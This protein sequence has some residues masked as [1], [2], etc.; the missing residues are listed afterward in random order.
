MLNHPS[1]TPC[2]DLTAQASGTPPATDVSSD[3]P[4]LAE[5]R[6][7]TRKLNNGR[8][9]GPDGI[10]PELLKCAETPISAALHKLFQN[11]WSSGRVPAEWRDGII[12][13][14]YKGKSHRNQCSSYRPI[15]LLSVPGK[16]FSHVLLSRLEP[17]FA[18]YRRPNQSG[19]TRGRSTLDDIK[20]AF[21]SV[22][23]D[24]FW[25]ALKATGV[26]PLLLQ[27]IQDLHVGS[28]STVRIGSRLR[29][30]GRDTSFTDL[31]YADD[32]ALF[33]GEPAQW[34]VS[35]QRFE[36]EAWMMGM[37]TSWVKTKIQ[38]C[39][40]LGPNPASVTVEGYSVEFTQ[41]FRYLGCDIHSSGYSSPDI[42]RRL[43]LASSTFG[44]LDCVWRNK[45]LKLTTKLRET[46]GIEDILVTIYRRRHSLFG[47][48][49]RLPEDTPAHVAL[50]LSVEA[51][52]GSC[53][54]PTWKRPRGRSR[55]TWVGQLEEDFES[56]AGQMCQSAA[57]RIGW[58]ALRP[59]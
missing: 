13:S 16:V 1:A 36:E 42:L 18:R 17:L 25:K 39:T 54:C 24:A 19:F 26:P 30:N 29:N 3:A 11:I 8:A 46:T 52:G 56:R 49:R 27:L 33:L 38:N 44:Q 14:L 55:S 10:S 22:D 57:E 58:A 9:A 51:R 2:Q 47:H 43:G 32:A 21:D 50:R 6:R 40:S 41:K 12:I 31:D 5:V 28:A 23:R 20:A 34:P 37:H 35:L 15:T 59:P 45:R 4:T 7:A 53:P 48:V